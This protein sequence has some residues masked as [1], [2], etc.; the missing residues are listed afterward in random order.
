MTREGRLA[1]G[2]SRCSHWAAIQLLPSGAY[3]DPSQ[4]ERLERYG[5]L[6]RGVSALPLDD[7][8]IEAPEVESVPGY[9]LVYG[10]FGV[11][12]SWSTSESAAEGGDVDYGAPCIIEGRTDDRLSI[13]HRLPFHLR[14]H[15]PSSNITH[16][17]VEMLQP[18]LFLYCLRQSTWQG[19]EAAI[20]I[21]GTAVPAGP[22]DRAASLIP[23]VVAD[24]RCTWQRARL[25]LSPTQHALV[26]VG[27]LA[28]FDLV[29]HTT[30]VTIFVATMVLLRGLWRAPQPM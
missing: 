15:R 10:P 18:E 2:G 29:L 19:E 26:P 27:Q 20:G 9:V 28:D 14:Y 5:S 25:E 12:R 7:Q 30:W 21:N 17:T 4:L 8:H 6:G 23:D 3:V 22:F 11:H 13:R 16:S 1:N 24:A